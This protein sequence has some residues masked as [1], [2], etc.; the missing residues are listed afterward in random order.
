[1]DQKRARTV[2]WTLIGIFAVIEVVFVMTLKNARI[3]HSSLLIPRVVFLFLT[4][5]VVIMH[6]VLAKAR[7]DMPG[8]PTRHIA[9]KDY[10]KTLDTS[11]RRSIR[12]CQ[13]AEGLVGI[14]AITFWVWAVA[15]NVPNKISALIY[16]GGSSDTRFFVTDAGPQIMCLGGICIACALLSAYGLLPRIPLP[17]VNAWRKHLTI[18]LG[19]EK[20]RSSALVVSAILFIGST[21]AFII[22]LGSYMRVSDQGIDIRSSILSS[23]EHYSWESISALENRQTHNKGGRLLDH[24][25]VRLAGGRE[26]TPLFDDMTTCRL[27]ENAVRYISRRTNTLI[28]VIPPR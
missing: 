26:W 3:Y 8:K 27:M 12:W 6:I 19:G 18:A 9:A 5:D 21:A 15:V 1:M 13:T 23:E 11:A 10:L 14:A 20:A 16:F 28:R 7:R 17:G 4:I 24:Y 22:L 25:A 2:F